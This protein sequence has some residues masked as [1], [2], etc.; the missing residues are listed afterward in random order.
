MGKGVVKNGDGSVVVLSPYLFLGQTLIHS[1]GGLL[2]A[3]WKPDNQLLYL[4]TSHCW[5]ARVLATER[6]STD[7]VIVM[8][9]M[10]MTI[11]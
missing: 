4:H 3:T 1:W 2:A 6:W 5:A 10:K 8:I 7:L 11:I 9:M